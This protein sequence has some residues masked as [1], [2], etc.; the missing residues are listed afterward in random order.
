MHK[1]TEKAGWIGAAVGGIAG[2]MTA[3]VCYVIYCPP[4]MG[5]LALGVLI[6]GGL[7]GSIGTICGAAIFALIAV[8]VRTPQSDENKSTS[9][10]QPQCPATQDQPSADGSA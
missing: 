5:K 4:D 6:S 8:I 3:V 1:S 7:L 10:G 9:N 2:V